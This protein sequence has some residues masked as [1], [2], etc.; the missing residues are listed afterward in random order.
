M[1]HRPD[2]TGVLMPLADVSYGPDVFARPVGDPGAGAEA[3]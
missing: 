2:H 3:G 1:L